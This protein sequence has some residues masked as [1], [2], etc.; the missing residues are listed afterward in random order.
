MQNIH[1]YGNNKKNSDFSRK[2]T[3]KPKDEKHEAIEFG[4][5]VV[6][7]LGKGNNRFM[8]IF[9]TNES[10]ADKQQSI[11]SRFIHPADVDK[12]ADD[13]DQTTADSSQMVLYKGALVDIAK[14][15]HQM[16][17]AELAREQTEQRFNELSKTNSE[18]QSSNSRAKD[19]LKDLQS[20]LK[21]A[22][23]K[24]SDAESGLTSANVSCI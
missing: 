21:S 12:S 1:F 9:Q 15:M 5:D 13:V 2:L 14:L 10:I 16:S 19:K 18:L 20:E 8:P 11:E 23:R 17:R 7:E 4:A 24:L 22:H 6:E 3:D